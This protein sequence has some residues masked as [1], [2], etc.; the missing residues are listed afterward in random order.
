MNEHEKTRIVGGTANVHSTWSC[1]EFQNAPRKSTPASRPSRRT[2]ACPA[3]RMCAAV[4]ELAYCEMREAPRPP[5]GARWAIS[6]GESSVSGR[7]R[8]DTLPVRIGNRPSSTRSSVFS[9][10][11]FG[12]TRATN[13]DGASGTSTRSPLSQEERQTDTHDRDAGASLYVKLLPD[14][15]ARPGVQRRDDAGA[16][17][18]E[19]RQARLRAEAQVVG[20]PDVPL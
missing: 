20:Q 18:E 15:I 4:N 1:D 5:R 12:P 14:S 13:S 3:S 2:P 11:P 6:R 16:R 19:H 10:P 17:T 7:R 8:S 9:P